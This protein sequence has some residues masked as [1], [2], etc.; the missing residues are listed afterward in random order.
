MTYRVGV[1][2]PRFGEFADRAHIDETDHAPTA[3]V[4]YAAPAKMPSQASSQASCVTQEGPQKAN[5]AGF[6]DVDR[7]TQVAEYRSTLWRIYPVVP[8]SPNTS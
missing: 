2:V 1:L 7:I 5:I 3:T 8:R 6:E 4:H